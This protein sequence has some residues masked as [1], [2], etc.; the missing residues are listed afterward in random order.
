MISK[1]YREAYCEVL[2]ILKYT[3]SEDV[4]KVSPK[5]IEYLK[6]N[7]SKTYVPNL[8]HSKKVKDM[9]LK[10]ETRA[11]LAIIYQKYWKETLR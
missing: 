3:R 1:E 7:A 4:A 8:D 11:V 9:D 2:D 6:K 5:F 10:I